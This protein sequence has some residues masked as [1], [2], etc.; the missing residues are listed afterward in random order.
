MTSA[1]FLAI[2]GALP[3][4]GIAAF[5]TDQDTTGQPVCNVGT[6]ANPAKAVMA[7]QHGTIQ[8]ALGTTAL[9]PAHVSASSS[10]LV[11]VRTM[12]PGAGNLTVQYAA[13]TADRVVGEPGAG[14]GFK[15]TALL[16]AGTINNADTSFVDWIIVG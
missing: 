14:G 16:A 3:A 5:V 15:I 12:T 13:L 2:N 9:I 11:T 7:V 10:I 4:K 1:Q 8:L 6:A